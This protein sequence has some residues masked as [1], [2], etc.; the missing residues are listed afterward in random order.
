MPTAE[1]NSKCVGSRVQVGGYYT[2]E[3]VRAGSCTLEVWREK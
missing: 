3:G 1:E 2:D